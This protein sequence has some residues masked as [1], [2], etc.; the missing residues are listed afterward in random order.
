M[1]SVLLL[2]GIYCCQVV[3]AQV[4]TE[5]FGNGKK[6]SEG[7]YVAAPTGISVVVASDGST[8]QA[9]TQTKNGPWVYWY[10]SGIKSAEGSRNGG[11]VVPGDF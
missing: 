8:R 7:A 3:S 10:D 2:I 4:Q 6:K 11:E 5:Y 1:K 9:P